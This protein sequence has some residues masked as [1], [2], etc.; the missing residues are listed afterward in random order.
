MELRR[1]KIA[2]PVEGK[3][4]H[5][6]DVHFSKQTTHEHNQRVTGDILEV[7]RSCEK[8]DAICVTGDLVS[9]HYTLLS[10]FDG[11]HLLERLRE[12]APVFYSLGN[13]E[14]DWA[15][16]E[17]AKFIKAAQK[18]GITVLDNE[19]AELGGI[20]FTGLTVPQTVFKN[21]GGHYWDLTPVTEPLIGRLV[22]NKGDLPTVLLAHTPLGLSGYAAWGAEAVL[23]GHV[24]G[25][26]VRVGNTG[27]LSPERRFLPKFTKGLYREGACTMN[28]SAGIGKFRLN[29]PAEVV[30]VELG[31]HL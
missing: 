18:C 16:E 23:S 10:Q 5:I 3:L 14:M 19:S 25:G 15:Q 21:P 11:L 8:A 30:C 2:F 12:I 13:H 17:R 20:R 28:V 4:L 29:N 31:K 24:H 6:S 7:C 26:I 22:G 9:R 27:L 1:E